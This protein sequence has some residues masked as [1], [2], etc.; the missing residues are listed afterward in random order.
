MS[1]WIAQNKP[2]KKIKYVV[3]KVDNLMHFFPRIFFF[4]HA[5]SLHTFSS[6][7]SC[8]LKSKRYFRPSHGTPIAM[9]KNIFKR[10]KI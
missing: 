3:F 8:L 1:F 10:K 6:L 2:N 9:G 7:L 5:L 4:R